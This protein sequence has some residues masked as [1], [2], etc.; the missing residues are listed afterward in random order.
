MAKIN[1]KLNL[2]KTPNIVENNSLIFAKNIRLDVNGDIHRDYA[3]K[4]ITYD[5]LTTDYISFG[6]KVIADILKVYDDAKNNDNTT[7]LSFYEYYL[8]KLKAI[9]DYN[10]THSYIYVNGGIDIVGVIADSNDFYLFCNGYYDY[11]EQENSDTKREAISIILKYS[12]DD[13]TLLPCNCNWNYSGGVIDGCVINNLV[14]DKIL[15][16][17]EITDD[18]NLVPF[19]CINLSY[20]SYTDDETLY[21]QTPN[22]PI[23]NLNYVGSFSYV[24]PCGVYQFFIRYKIRDGFYT[25][26]FPASREIFAGNNSATVTNFGTLKYTN[27]NT[28]S[29]NSFIFSVEHLFEEYKSNYDSFQIGFILSHDDAIYARAWKHFKL[30]ETSI[31]F[32]YN[33]K[34]AEEI[35]I[36]DLTKQSY[37]LFN[38]GNVTSFKNKLYLSN[39]TETNFDEDLQGVANNVKIEIKEEE[40]TEGYG[41][42]PV[43]TTVNGSTQYING[44]V[45]EETN[46]LLTGASGIIDNLMGVES[47]TSKC[48]IRT[49]LNYSINNDKGDNNPG[50]AG[51]MAIYGFTVSYSRDY[52]SSIQDAATRTIRGF[53][54]YVS[55]PT[56]E[57]NN[58]TAIYLDGEK[59][60][61][62]DSTK[63]ITEK[64]YN[65]IKY[66][67]YSGQF[68]DNSY[69]V[70]Q[71]FEIKLERKCKYKA[72]HY[73]QIPQLQEITPRALVQSPNTS[74]TLVTRDHDY[75]YYQ[76]IIITFSAN[77]TL[78][79]NDNVDALLNYTTLIPYQR[80]KFYIHFVKQTGEI[81]NGYYCN[82]GSVGEITV[83]YKDKADAVIYPVFSNI[84]IPEGYVACFF[85]IFHS[86]VYSST[87]FNLQKTVNTGTI[88]IEGSCVEANVRLIPTVS[89]ITCKQEG[90]ATSGTYHYCSDSSIIRYFGCDGVISFEDELLDTS[91]VAYA[92]T[93]Y[94]SQQDVDVVLTKC[95]QFIEKGITEYDDCKNIN[96]LGYI[97]KYSPLDRD[98]CISYYSDGSNVYK[99]ENENDVAF[100][101][102]NMSLVL[103]ELGK[104]QSDNPNILNFGLRPTNT[105]TIYSNYN[106]NYLSLTEDVK[107]TIKSY[108]PYNESDTSESKTPA[109]SIICRLLTSLTLSD[110]YTLPS[111]YNSYTRKQYVTYSK[112]SIVRFDNTIRSSELAGDESRISVFKFNADDYY[113]VPTNRGKIVNMIAVGDSIIVHTRDSMFRFTG[114]N[115]L[116]GSTGEIVT[117]ETEPFNTGISEVFGSDFGFAGLQNKQDC[118][119]TEN[120]YIFFDRDAKIVYLYAGQ[121]QIEKISDKIEKLF[122]YDDINDVYFANDFY[123]N[124]FFICVVFA[125][126]TTVTLS[127]SMLDG[128]KS[129][130][131][132]HDFEFDKAFNTKVNCYFITKDRQNVCVVDK[133]RYGIYEGL[134]KL[135]DTIYPNK[136]NRTYDNTRIDPLVNQ[137]VRD[138]QYNLSS[139]IDIIVNENY[140]LVKTLNAISWC[141]RFIETNFK[142]ISK[143]NVRDLLMSEPEVT[144]YPC[145]SIRIYTD[146]CA[147]DLLPCDKISNTVSISDPNS[148]K[149]PRFNQGK[150][151]LNYFRN[152]L[153][154]DDLFNYL[155]KYDNGRAKAT[156]QSDD[157][158]LIEGK[159]FVIRFIFDG[160]NKIIANDIY[161]NVDFKL[162]TLSVNSKIKI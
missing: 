78:I 64:I 116:S 105:V 156:L 47:I 124:R 30:Y 13:D 4:P 87:V 94:T 122:D 144:E 92:I 2:N 73:E 10:I 57:N 37:Q 58:I 146:T 1:P 46:K 8:D 106:L 81:T 59:I 138:L 28:D 110:V 120:G 63:A 45:V 135:E 15:N 36:T 154:A 159:Y 80:Y 67:N 118:I 7:V 19:K 56:F 143:N 111:M 113:N 41:D 158:S 54:N 68:L 33:A 153:N 76:N 141:S 34:D 82:G 130:V 93:D 101:K 103:K 89:K 123:N 114:S 99:K 88:K 43:L 97:C 132:L 38:V 50:G 100:D 107:T 150:W 72:Q 162:E 147:T 61:A 6:N 53:S 117:N 95:T 137:K 65:T 155:P 115:N 112:D 96:L 142:H 60:E 18:A 23:T 98:T 77:Q 69:N 49:M 90:V 104:Y 131:S 86:G 17:G 32:D 140:E 66:L 152:I 62:S 109:Q 29:D 39:Y 157:N 84:V 79:K 5:G 40:A 24:I 21:T 31:N 75:V 55:G 139:I 71:R 91:K 48:S 16:I 51:N 148:Y 14:G 25:D 126:T 160:E 125:D 102:N 20:S 119:V 161:R 9:T 42:Y 149:Y 83:D 11:K 12:E 22:I 136:Y 74:G 128:I 52:L 3:I 133:T 44:I 151:T 26:W 145:S 134:V 85:S 127:Y 35:E 108:Y 70:K 121:N 129:F 27:I